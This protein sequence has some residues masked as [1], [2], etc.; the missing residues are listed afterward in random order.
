MAEYA[1]AL[2]PTWTL[3]EELE[4]CPLGK[5]SLKGLLSASVVEVSS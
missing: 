3:Q 1:M 5:S 2:W 4:N